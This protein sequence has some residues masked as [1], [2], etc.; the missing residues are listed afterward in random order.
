MSKLITVKTFTYSHELSIIRS[1]LE[2]EGIYCFAQDELTTQV[3]PFSSIAIGGVKL[4]VREED[5]PRTIQILKENGYISER[6]LEPSKLQIKLY[7][8]L[9][10][11]PFLKKI[12][13]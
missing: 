7:K 4:Q 5:V 10:H 1:K 8:V 6:D 9:S 11:I 3:H 2:S 12:Y 13:D